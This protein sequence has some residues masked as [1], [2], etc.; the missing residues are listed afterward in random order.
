M[1]SASEEACQCG[2]A[3]TGAAFCAICG[4][5]DGNTFMSSSQVMSTM[6]NSED[7]TD[8]A[9]L[10]ESLTDTGDTSETASARDFS[11]GLEAQ[12][13]PTLS[14]DS[15]TLQPPPGIRPPPGLELLL[16][17]ANLGNRMPS[18]KATEVEYGPPGEITT[19]MICDIPCRRNI[20]Q[21]IAT[22]DAAGFEKTYD[23][24]YMPGRKGRRQA[25]GG[26]VGYAFVNFKKSEWAMAFME[27][28]QNVAFPDSS[29]TKL[30]YAKPARDQGF[31]ANYVIHGRKNAVGSLLTFCDDSQYMQ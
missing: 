27:S 15:L 7:S 23:F 14:V 21:L 24:V 4:Q 1:G 11:P 18:A 20:E 17:A 26:N 30:G 22:I 31:A 3:G 16:P 28:F 8:G 25:Q 13:D 29:S 6:Y 12:S 9:Y 19:L 5:A 2:T 10:S